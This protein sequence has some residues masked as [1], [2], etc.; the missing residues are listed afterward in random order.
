METTKNVKAELAILAPP[1]NN[2][3]FVNS[4]VL[5]SMSILVYMFISFIPIEKLVFMLAVEN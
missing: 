5:L 1:T 4:I 2:T 3:M